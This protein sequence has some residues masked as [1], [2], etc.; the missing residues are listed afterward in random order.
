VNVDGDFFPCEKVSETSN[1]MRIGNL[2]SG[3]EIDKVGKLINISQMNAD[4]CKNCWAFMFCEIC[5]RS[6]DNEG[7]LSINKMRELCELQ[8]KNA[9]L[10]LREI[11]LKY[12]FERLYKE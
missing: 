11:T 5:A 7:E 12:E 2:S 10:F 6:I 4:N 9:M 1:A 8:R 3:F